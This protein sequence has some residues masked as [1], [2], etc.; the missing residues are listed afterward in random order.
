MLEN[1]AIIARIA[2][3]CRLVL[4]VV[5]LLAS[6]WIRHIQLICAALAINLPRIVKRK[7]MQK[8]EPIKTFIGDV[9]P[10]SRQQFTWYG[11]D[12]L[13]KALYAGKEIL[14]CINDDDATY[15]L[16]YLDMAHPKNFNNPDEAKLEAKAFA[17]SVLNYMI[18]LISTSNPQ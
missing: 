11:G 10:L 16:T 12:G 5:T 9:H 6:K 17:I 14:I 13:Y 4:I 2:L 1:L 18:D 15:Q 3:L 7:F 8:I